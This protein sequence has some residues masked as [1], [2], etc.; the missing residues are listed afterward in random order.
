[1]TDGIGTAAAVLELAGAAV[2]ASITL[3]EVIS[4][5]RNAPKEILNLNGDLQA[6]STL[7]KN[8]ELAL[9][10]PNTQRIVDQDDEV[11]SAMKGLQGLVSSCA[12]ACRD[13]SI[14]LRSFSQTKIDD[15]AVEMIEGD[16][17][18]PG[19]QLK[20]ESFDIRGGLSWLFKR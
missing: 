7:L 15:S 18:T 4:T 12:G 13:V 1:M 5:I 16:L 9:S 8:L 3:Y 14:R 11:R 17:Y 2:K 10:S 19:H 6:L 20:R